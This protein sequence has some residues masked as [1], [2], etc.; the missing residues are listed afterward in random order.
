MG[1]RIALIED[2]PELREV[3]SS[4]LEKKGFEV[5]SAPSG[6]DIVAAVIGKKPSLVIVDLNL[7]GSGGDDVI[8]TFKTR[9]MLD[10]VPVILISGCDEAEVKRAAVSIGAAAYFCKPFDMDI[11]LEAV[12]KHLSATAG[13]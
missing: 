13:R 9:G 7:P 5:Y 11:L 12:K 8:S 6:F 4:Y 10:G 2:D 1:N 3:L